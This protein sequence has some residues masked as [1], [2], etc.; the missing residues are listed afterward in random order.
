MMTGQDYEFEHGG[1]WGTS[2]VSWTCDNCGIRLHSPSDFD[3]IDGEDICN[4]CLKER[5]SE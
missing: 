5:E 1:I 4:K 3:R 2:S